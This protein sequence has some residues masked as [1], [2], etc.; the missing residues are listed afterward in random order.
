MQISRQQLVSDN[1]S[2][3]P[4]AARTGQPWV[5]TARNAR[6]WL[7]AA[8]LVLLACRLAL[9]LFA[10]LADT[11]EARYGEIARQTA[12]NGFWL[13]PHMDPQ[14]PFFAKPPLSTWFSAASMQLFGINEF[15][16]RLPALLLSLLTI[17]IALAFAKELRLRERWLVVPVLASAPMFFIS[18]GAVMTDAA[19][20]TVIT[21]ALYF[22]W[23]ALDAADRARGRRWRLAFWAMIGIGALSKGLATWALIGLPL[24]A[25]ALVQRRPLQMLRQVFDWSGIAIAIALFLPWYLAAEHDYPGFINYFIIGEHFSRFL[26]PGWAGDRYGTAHREPLGAIW[27]FWAG[28]VLPWLGVFF[29][30]L[31]PIVRG[32]RRAMAPLPCFLWC[33]TLAPL[34]FFT[35]SRNIISTYALTAVP[36]FAVLVAHW[37]DNRP[38][39]TR[40]RAAAGLLA[41]SLVAL[42][43]TPLV[44]RQA[45][46]NSERAL[47]RTFERLAGPG[48]QLLYSAAPSF[49]SSFYTHGTLRRI[50]AGTPVAAGNFVVVDNEEVKRQAIPDSAVRFAGKLRT[51]VEK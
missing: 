35:V 8:C 23:R 42:A 25:F 9:M 50:D 31:W 26:V 33:A 22:A 43:L 15:A 48:A 12:S 34:V 28:A 11:T 2:S 14:T 37:L 39:Q 46:A 32:R 44:I 45:G 13:M 36:P 29:S 4:D 51:L 6:W 41:Y 21:A 1:E 7:L 17:G 20:M 47:V 3:R 5:P 38:Q 19:Q 30:E 24:I 40:H 49:S 27:V 16:A 18:A 10:P